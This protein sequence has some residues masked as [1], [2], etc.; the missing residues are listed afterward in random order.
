MDGVE[1]VPP[2]RRFIETDAA[3]TRF[4]SM[5]LCPYRT[6]VKII[7]LGL[8]SR[9]KDRDQDALDRALMN[10]AYSDGRQGRLVW[11]WTQYERIRRDD[12]RD[13]SR[14]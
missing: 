5:P 2:E 13:N 3:L 6:A 11:G 12:G 10:A 9:S 7:L 4:T 14:I 8:K 1:A